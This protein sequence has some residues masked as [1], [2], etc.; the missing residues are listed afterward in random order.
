M[1]KASHSRK[2]SLLR[3][4]QRL[5]EF[6]WNVLSKKNLGALT[7]NKISPFYPEEWK[8]CL[9]FWKGDLKNWAVYFHYKIKRLK[10]QVIRPWGSLRKGSAF[11]LQRILSP[12]EM[13]MHLKDWSACFLSAYFIKNFVNLNGCFV[14]L[15]RQSVVIEVY[16]VLEKKGKA[17]Y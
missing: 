10:F 15:L 12:K 5:R 2:I 3:L 1:G 8:R 11:I 4:V 7:H 16:F 9:R 14:F 13:G 17:K 6:R